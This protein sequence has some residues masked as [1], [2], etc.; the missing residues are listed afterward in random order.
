MYKIALVLGVVSLNFAASH[1]VQAQS[2]CPADCVSALTCLCNAAF[3]NDAD[4]CQTTAAETCGMFS[5]KLAQKK[6]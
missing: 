3:P 2:N 5:D 6:K 4:W 1:A